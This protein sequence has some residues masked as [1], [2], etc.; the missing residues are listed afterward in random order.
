MAT[1]PSGTVFG[2]KGLNDSAKRN[3]TIICSSPCDF[4]VMTREDYNLI[5]KDVSKAQNDKRKKF[6][7]LKVFPNII[8]DQIAAKIS[9]DFF[10]QKIKLVRNQIIFKQ[11][12]FVEYIYIVKKGSVLL[13]KEE[14][15]LKKRYNHMLLSKLRGSK[16][17]NLGVLG[18]GSIFGETS[19]LLKNK[20]Q[21]FSAVCL[22]DCTLLRATIPCMINHM[23]NFPKLN[24]FLMKQFRNGLFMRL[25]LMKSQFECEQSFIRYTN[26]INFGV[27]TMNNM[28]SNKP[29]GEPI[30]DDIPIQNYLQTCDA[31]NQSSEISSRDRS[32]PAMLDTVYLG[33]Q[34]TPHS[35]KPRSKTNSS[36][37]APPQIESF[38]AVRSRRIRVKIADLERVLPPEKST[39]SNEVFK[40]NVGLDTKKAINSHYR[41]KISNKQRMRTECF[42]SGVSC[43]NIISMLRGTLTETAEVVERIISRS[44]PST[45]QGVQKKIRPFSTRIRLPGSAKSAS[46]SSSFRE[47]DRAEN[48][49]RVG[50]FSVR[51]RSSILGDAI[52]VN[53]L[54]TQHT[55]RQKY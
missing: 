32:K 1:L 18:P 44:R 36:K 49:I 20:K 29:E 16:K 13:Y 41:P 50:C 39:F 4:G 6:F 47:L 33:S 21:F 40:R 24:D 2:E 28:N 25:K 23:R 34:L 51:P 7:M 46:R 53:S 14:D 10:K 8:Q 5:L 3:A 35:I 54:N 9:Y 48:R 26:S 37:G 55:D 19:L 17:F 12:D 52:K 45:S 15:L 38:S 22:N 42:T 11:T 30:I 43:R 31:L 27:D